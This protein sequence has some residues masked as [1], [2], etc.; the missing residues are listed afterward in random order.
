VPSPAAPYPAVPTLILQ[1]GEDL[2]TP[3]EGSARVASQIAGAQRVVVPGVG[4][5]VVGGDPTGC[6]L[7]ALGRFLDGEPGR[8]DCPRVATGVPAVAL[9]PRS[10]RSVAPLRRLGGRAG[11]TAAAIGST[12]DDLAF[13]LSP[14]FLSYSGGGLR[15]GWFK[16]RR[17]KVVVHRYAAVRGMWVTGVASRGVIRLRVGGRAAAHGRVTLRS[18]G[19]LRGRLGGRRVRV[20]LPGFGASAMAAGSSRTG[21][22]ADP[23]ARVLRPTSITKLSH[24]GLVPSPAR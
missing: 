4:H 1:G 23:L 5:A 11:R 8:G 9:P 22:A 12:I 14:A 7:R 24:P 6:G 16:V 13:A 10:L 15:G 20:R 19:R 21:S 17:G 2:R 18:G 3:P